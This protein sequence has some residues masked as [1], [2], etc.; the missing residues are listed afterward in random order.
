M[1]LLQGEDQLS[2]QRHLHSSTPASLIGFWTAVKISFGGD[3]V[4]VIRV[5]MK[6]IHVRSIMTK[7]TFITRSYSEVQLARAIDS[8]EL[9]IYTKPNFY[10]NDYKAL[11]KSQ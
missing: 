10:K 1:T 5:F 7:S 2:T 9:M 8:Y 11:Y 4:R 6:T 3:L